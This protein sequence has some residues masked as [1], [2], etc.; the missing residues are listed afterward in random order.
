[1]NRV[2]AIGTIAALVIGLLAGFLYWG[3]P[4]RQL[5]AELGQAR[6]QPAALERELEASRQQ[7]TKV[8]TE[9]RAAQQRLKELEQDLAFERG[10]RDKLEA[11]LSRGRK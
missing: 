8:E 11:I 4:A 1:M 3:L 9:L 6:E 7:T 10:R 5:R 2:M